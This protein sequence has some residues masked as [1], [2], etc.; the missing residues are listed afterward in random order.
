[1]NV[2]D[3][4]LAKNTAITEGSNLQFRV[5]MLNAFN[6]TNYG[7]P[8][9]NITASNFGRITGTRGARVVQLYLRF[10]F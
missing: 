7:N 4:S 6:H 1:L 3:L 5:D 2:L 8:V 9:T 10:T